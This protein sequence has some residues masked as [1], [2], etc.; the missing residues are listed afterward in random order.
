MFD[1]DEQSQNKTRYTVG[2]DLY[3]AS[4]EDMQLWIE[5]LRLDIARIEAEI[6]KKQKERAEADAIFKTNS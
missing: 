2:Q 3:A 1:S 4:I 5:A 6:V